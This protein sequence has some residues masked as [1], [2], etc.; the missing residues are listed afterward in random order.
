MIRSISLDENW[1]KITSGKYYFKYSANFIP[2]LNDTFDCHCE[3]NLIFHS[4][5]TFHY[6][7][8]SLKGDFN[9]LSMINP[10]PPELFFRRFSGHSLR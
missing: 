5:S 3:N 9:V 1:L 10:L 6:S 8:K 4:S 2:K 7:K